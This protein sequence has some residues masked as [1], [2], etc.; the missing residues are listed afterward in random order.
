MLSLGSVEQSTF[1]TCTTLHMLLS[2]QR[3]Q[4][5][6]LTSSGYNFWSFA[7]YPSRLAAIWTRWQAQFIWWH[8]F[9][10][11]T[12]HYL[13]PMQ[14]SEGACEP[15]SW[16]VCFAVSS[17]QTQCAF[18]LCVIQVT[19]PRD[20]EPA[21]RAKGSLWFL[22]LLRAPALRWK[23]P[24]LWRGVGIATCWEPRGKIHVEAAVGWGFCRDAGTCGWLT[25]QGFL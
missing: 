7:K 9:H 14:Y 4:I 12:T 6:L 5:S 8:F 3:W 21:P 1:L 23:A 17:C 22:H 11:L 24:L 16:F 2:G 19:H 20:T 13:N 25:L 15:E 10:V 18:W